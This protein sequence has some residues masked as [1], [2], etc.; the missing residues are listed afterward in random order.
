MIR[1]PKIKS[2]MTA[3]P[4][5]V[6]VET[7]VAEALE[8]MRSHSIHH[9]PV[10]DN[11]VVIGIVSD[12]DIDLLAGAN[13]KNTDQ[14]LVGDVQRPD[15]YIVDL[16]ERLDVVLNRMANNHINAAVVTRHGRLVGLFTS[17]DAQRAFAE[18][19]REQFRRSGGGDAA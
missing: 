1:M 4:Y 13:S 19:L 10:M 17:S 7:P 3:F 12:R 8:L 9:L 14:I 5:S 15:P 6:K 16:Q 2:V 18:F 11:N